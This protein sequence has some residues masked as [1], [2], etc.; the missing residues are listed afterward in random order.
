[1]R[2]RA[3]IVAGY[4]LVGAIAITRVAA[5]HRIF[6]ATVDE[7]LN[8][9]CGLDWLRGLSYMDDPSHPPLARAL[10][11]V[12][13]YLLRV[14]TSP[15]P[16]KPAA[17]GIAILDSGDYVRN[18]SLAR[19]GNLVFLGLGLLGTA[20]WAAR[21]FGPAGGLIAAALFSWLPPVLAHAGLATTD[22][23]VA[24]LLPLSLVAFDA[25]LGNPTLARGIGFGTVMG[26]GLLTKFS[27]LV[28]FPVAA[29]VVVAARTWRGQARFSPGS[30][31][32]ALA[33]ACLIVWAG[34]RFEAGTIARSHPA[35]E[36][37]FSESFPRSFRPAAAWFS[38]TVPVPAP[39]F[40]SG[41]AMVRV[42]NHAGH[43]AFLFG[44][45]TQHGWW[46]YFPVALFFKTPLSFLVL[47]VIGIAFVAARD[48][49]RIDVALIPVAMLAAVLPTSIN[50]GI[51][52]VLPIYAPLAVAAAGGALALWKNNRFR[53][54][55]ALL[56]VGTLVE[57][58]SAHPDYLA[59]FNKMAGAHPER[60][61]V[62]SNLD[63][64]QD[65][66]RLVKILH[67]RGVEHIFQLPFGSF[68]L[69]RYGIAAD[70]FDPRRHAPGWY[71]LSES[72]LALDPEARLGSYL[73]LDDY[74]MTR[75]GKSL[76]LYQV[77]SP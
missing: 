38:R 58:V 56:V 5:T 53:A 22:M 72:A 2:S 9:A 65:Y 43:R 76:R 40:F 69:R 14:P 67:E 20:L 55:G 10:S 42:H 50:I 12:P 34:F 16:G 68:E 62:D 63:W 39:L 74:P 1:M 59:W 46:Y 17:E 8:I 54:I 66:L 41:A 61:L 27:F 71:V 57:S 35:A 73:W 26:I 60:I 15:V 45:V 48:R 52:H 51:R 18:I 30:A 49:R 23:A 13:A 28:F 47:A 6:S 19:L 33:V 25:W 3:L 44:R 24:A 11:A 7:P 29:L 70:W 37:A 32:A 75:V 31:A 21:A 4:V 36:F 77:G 64:G